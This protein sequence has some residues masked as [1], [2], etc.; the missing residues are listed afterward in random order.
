MK[1]HRYGTLATLAALA[2]V[3]REVI[4]QTADSLQSLE[5][6]SSAQMCAAVRANGASAAD[7]LNLI[8]SDVAVKTKAAIDASNAQNSLRECVSALSNLPMGLDVQMRY[9][10]VSGLLSKIVERAC[11]VV[12]QEV[13][14]EV[15]GLRS[16][17][18]SPQ[19]YFGLQGAAAPLGVVS[20]NT[21]DSSS[22]AANCVW[23]WLNSRP[24]HCR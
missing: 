6:S 13:T 23:D 10:G 19:G 14:S 7:R 12:N 8:A 11:H 22:Y 15:Q 17:F 16:R 9:P 21:Q 20:V 4:G 18:G 2:L 1:N 24:T 5:T 3:S